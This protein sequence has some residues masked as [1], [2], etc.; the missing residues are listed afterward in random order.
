M[1]KLRQKTRN[2]ECKRAVNWISKAIRRMIQTETFEQWETKLAN[3]E[4]THQAIW[5]IAKS[6]AN[7][8]GPKAPTAINGP[9]GPK[10]QSVD[11]TNA[12]ADW[13]EKQFAPH[14]LCDEN[15]EWQVEATVQALLEAEN[16][17]PKEL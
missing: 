10:F 11:K 8:G 4:I 16:N 5:P 9:S 14:K 12:I 1:R 17:D 6:L 7:M 13:L 2:P 15:H 3:T